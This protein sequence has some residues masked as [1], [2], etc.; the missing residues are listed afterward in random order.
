[1]EHE[2]KQSKIDKRRT[3][4]PQGTDTNNTSRTDIRKEASEPMYLL[5]YE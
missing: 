2:K 1:M 5:R 3:F 4:E